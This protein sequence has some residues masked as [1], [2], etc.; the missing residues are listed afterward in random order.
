MVE[1][2][3]NP[4]NQYLLCNAILVLYIKLIIKN[5]WIL[6]QITKNR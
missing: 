4:L 1:F 6:E 3:G 5:L 2:T